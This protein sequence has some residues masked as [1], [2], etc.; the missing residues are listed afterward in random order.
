[1]GSGFDKLST[2]DI[3][4]AVDGI[5][6]NSGVFGEFLIL[7]KQ[8]LRLPSLMIAAVVLDICFRIIAV[9]SFILTMSFTGAV[10]GADSS[11]ETLLSFLPMTGCIGTILYMA[12]YWPRGL[13]VSAFDMLLS[14]G[15]AGLCYRF[16]FPVVKSWKMFV[17]AKREN[18]LLFLVT[19][20]LTLWSFVGPTLLQ[21]ILK[22]GFAEIAGLRSPED[23]DLSQG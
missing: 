14:I 13:L 11:K 10:Y 18:V 23:R 2:R 5:S 6:V 17:N 22:R 16:L 8:Y 7:E 12:V 3:P 4:L 1:M 9:F 20:A 21:E 15:I 19:T